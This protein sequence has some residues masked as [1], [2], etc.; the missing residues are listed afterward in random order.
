MLR[1]MQCRVGSTLSAL[2]F[3]A[4]IAAVLPAAA[5][6]TVL[7]MHSR[8]GD[9]IGA[10]GN[11]LHTPADGSFTATKNFDNG[12]SL[13]FDGGAAVWWMVDF[14][15]PQNAPLTPGTYDLATRY[16]FQ[17]ATEPGL[18]VS[19]TGRGCNML[20]G[21]FTVLEI[22]YGAG[23]TI[24]SFAA[25]FEQHCEGM[26]AALYGSVRFNASARAAYTVAVTTAGAGG[27][28]VTSF[29]IGI[30]CG[31]TCTTSVAD[32]LI[33]AL[34]ATPAAG[35][36]FAGWTGPADCADGV[37]AE[38][39]SVAC[40]A[41]FVPCVYS[42]TPSSTTLGASGGSG[43]ATVTATPGC[44]WTPMTTDDWIFVDPQTRSGTQPLGFTYLPRGSYSTS[45]TATVSVGTATF[46]LTQTGVTP[47]L[48]VSPREIQVPPS[49][50]T[51][52]VSVFSNV[53]DVSWT[54]SSNASWLS[55]PTGGL[56]SAQVPITVA[57]NLSPN[58]RAG[59]VVIAGAVVTVYQL[60]DGPP[61]KPVRFNATVSG[62]AG[63]FTWGA[64]T[65]ADAYWL[66]AGLAPGDT[67]VRFTVPAPSTSYQLPQVPPGLYFLR[68][69]AVNAKGA[70]DRKSVV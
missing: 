9:Y 49:G 55:V 52:Q 59:T 48:T 43:Q 41:T 66:E 69:R 5:Q 10:G 28:T 56:A 20:T 17:A 61:A 22:V 18:S 39:A 25:N 21:R 51:L 15:A 38:G 19:G 14:A 3:A 32:G 50:G 8:P 67:Q 26:A 31:V 12:V 13:R 63:F 34:I 4:W 33:T 30:T 68:L 54:S 37:V 40:G 29:P 1:G 57:A 53:V 64:V 2:T 24:T 16:P 11:W 58:S 7:L 23:T 47:Q 6:P 35:S 70:R 45:R 62:F 60:P 27:G 46:T 44:S 65:G 42:I 36:T